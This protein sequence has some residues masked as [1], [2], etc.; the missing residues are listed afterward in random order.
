MRAGKPAQMWEIAHLHK[1]GSR[2]VL[3]IN[4][5][6]VRDEDGGNLRYRGVG[7]NITNRRRTEAALDQERYLLHALM[8]NLPHNIYFKDAE[9]RFIRINKAMAAHGVK[10]TADN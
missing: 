7:R 8:D 4:A 2:V 5:E 10:S 3:E 6:P 9:S 1:D